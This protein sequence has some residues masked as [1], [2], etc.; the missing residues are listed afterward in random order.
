MSE[1][2]RVNLFATASEKLAS[3]RVVQD[4]QVPV[5]LELKDYAIPAGAKI[6]AYARGHYAADTYRADCTYS[7]NVITLV[8]PVGFFVP[9]PNSLQFEIDG[10][11]IPFKVVAI[12]EE[13]LSDPN[14]TTSTPEIVKPLVDQARAI[15][16]ETKSIAVRTPYVGE[17]GNWYVWDTATGTFKDSGEPSKGDPFVYSDFTQEQ[18]AAL[19][20]EKGDP[21]RYSDFTE[22]QLAVL[23]GEKGDPF[24]YSDFTE[25]QLAALKGEKGDPFQYSDFTAEQLNALKG[26]KGDPFRY[27]DF[28]EAQLAALKGATGDPATVESS[29]TTYQVGDSGTEAP[30]GDWSATIPTVPQGKY[31]W[32]KT[33]TQFN[34]GAPITTTVVS[35]FGV[36]GAGSVTTV[37]SVAPDDAGNVPLKAENIPTTVDGETVESE[38][39]NL[40]K[41]KAGIPA[42]KIGMLK[43]E[44]N[45]DEDGGW[46]VIVVATAGVDYQLPLVAGTDYQTPLTA[47]TDYQTPL[48]AG[49]DYQAPLTGA[50]GKYVGF[51]AENVPEA[52]D[53]PNASTTA[54][55]VTYL[56]DSY[57]RTDTDKAATPRSVNNVYKLLPIST[58]VELTVDGWSNGV[59]TVSVA[60]VTTTDHVIVA[61]CPDAYPAYISSNVRCTAQGDGTLMFTATTTPTAGMVINVIILKQ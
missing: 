25:A 52:M 35:R 19:K 31:L 3:F 38:L 30:T 61:P 15:L 40:W 55:G 57:T 4:S 2:I 32:A 43:S 41:Q 49:V 54:K 16:D 11:I 13:R 59:Q 34:S 60:G 48:T 53:L 6:S 23:K 10:R 29:A 44:A 51:S 14:D 27:S 42:G 24:R 26:E 22:A 58:S 37:N 45:T 39:A 18:L 46:P 56:V 36:D 8:P 7:G 1:T 12:C 28:T 20:G 17:N 50:K 21:F 9:G 33:V 47:G 5:E